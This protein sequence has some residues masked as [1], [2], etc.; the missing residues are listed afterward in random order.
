MDF[1]VPLAQKEGWGMEFL[2][3]NMWFPILSSELGVGEFKR[4]A[5]RVSDFTFG[6]LRSV[7]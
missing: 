5:Q 3:R 4:E 2:S 7:K 1:L 6:P